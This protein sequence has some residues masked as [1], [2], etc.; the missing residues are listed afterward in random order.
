M[1]HTGCHLVAIAL[2]EDMGK[3]LRGLMDGGRR[4]VVHM[5]VDT[6]R[7]VGSHDLV[8]GLVLGKDDP[9][10]E[11]WALAHSAEPGAADNASG[12]AA[13]VAAARAIEG[14]IRAGKLAR[15]RRTIRF[16]NG[17]ECYSFFHYMEHVRRLQ[18]ALAGLVVLQQAFG[19]W[20]GHD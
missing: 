2:S 5:R 16:L 14:A 1:E 3:W 19:D 15:P 10:E 18:P 17:Y 8:S 6:R 4:V 7:Y 12:V 9:Q 11:V 13:C 20:R